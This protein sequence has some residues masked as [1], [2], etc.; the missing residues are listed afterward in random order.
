MQHVRHIYNAKGYTDYTNK[1]IT[2]DKNPKQSH[3]LLN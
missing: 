3:T 2:I 1:L